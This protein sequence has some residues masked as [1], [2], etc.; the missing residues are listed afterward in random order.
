MTEKGLGDGRIIPDL[1]SRKHEYVFRIIGRDEKYSLE[2]KCLVL[3]LILLV[4]V[5]IINILSG[6]HFEYFTWGWGNLLATVFIGFFTWFLIRFVRKVDS[7]IRRITEILSPPKSE[8]D[9]EGNE[10]WKILGGRIRKYKQWAHHRLAR[11]EWYYFAAAV[12]L[13]CGTIIGVLT[14]DPDYGWV[15]NDPYRLKE[16]YLRAW[17]AFYG[18]FIATSI[19]YIISGHNVIRRYCKDVISHEEILPLDP[20][21]TGGLKELG[22]LSL[23]LG[24]IVALPSVAF[25]IYLLR[26][27]IFE[28]LGFTVPPPAVQNEMR[29][30]A[31]ISPL[32]A[33]LLVLVFFGSIS[34]AHDDMVRAKNAYL[35]KIHMEY[36]D[37][38]KKLLHK[39]ETKRQIKPEE[40]KRLSNLHDLYDK[41]QSMAVWPLDFRTVVRFTITS[42]LPLIGVGITI[43]I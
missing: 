6:T 41:V 4:P 9:R 14:I 43:S 18:F 12:G 22:R 25:P 2:F 29:I 40:Y 23:D 35:L 16:F 32:Y 26:F 34:P 38:H 5:L 31:V 24:L 11:L 21:H 1:L 33:L 28:F 36:K 3:V 37:M 30:A 7:E 13:A 15:F 27:R 19:T 39:L 8:R 17:Y 20:D 42:S 10:E